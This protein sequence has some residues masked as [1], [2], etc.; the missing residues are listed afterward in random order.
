MRPFFVFLLLHLVRTVSRLF[1]RYELGWVGSRRPDGWRDLRMIA[2]LNHT[3]LFEVLL[4]GYADSRLL[5]R[6]ARHAVLPVAEKTLKRRIGVFFRFLAANVIEITRQ[7][8]HTW[9][10]VLNGID[11]ESIVIILPEG[12]MKRRNGLD[13]HG[14]PMTVRGGVVDILD[15]M[16]SGRILLIYN[17]G[18]HHIQVPDEGLPRLFQ[19][20][21]V[22]MEVVDIAE[23]KLAMEERVSAG[24][25]DDFRSAVI[26]D[27]THRRD[28]LAPPLDEPLPRLRYKV[29]RQ[30]SE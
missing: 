13:S 24:E 26:R 16:S 30:A 11:H 8:D 14:R 7:R 4:A 17:A 20:I 12:R 10:A 6:F 22:N 25:A 21:R 18:L 1:Y 19:T 27:L 23:Y 2:I 3:S 15:A 5:W 29:Y 28:T 9:A